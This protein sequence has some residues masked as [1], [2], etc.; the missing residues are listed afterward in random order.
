MRPSPSKKEERVEDCTFGESKELSQ[1][2][3]LES[4]KSEAPFDAR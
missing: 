2:T 3:R 1:Q 4:A